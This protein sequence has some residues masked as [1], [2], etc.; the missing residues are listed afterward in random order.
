MA[1][2]TPLS[3]GEGEEVGEVKERS[4]RSPRLA[5]L[6]VFRGL[7]IALMIF[8]DY[9]GSI[10]P[11]VA[12]S[13]WHG[14][15]LADFVTPFFL[16]IA[17]IS[18]SLVYKRTSNKFLATKKA[19]L[20]TVKL[21]LLGILLQGGYFHGVNSLTFGVDLELIRWFGILQRIAIG[22][23][24]AALCEIWLS[25]IPWMNATNVQSYF[26]R[27]YPA[28]W[29]FVLSLCGIYLGLLYGLYVPD[30]QFEVQQAIHLNG[31][32]NSTYIVKKVTC[33]VIGDL[34]PACNSAGMIDRYFLGSEHLYK[35][36]AYRNLKICQTSEVSD[37]DNLPSWCQA[38]FDP[39]GLLGSLMAAVTCILGLQYGHILVRVEDHKDRLRYWLLFS[40]SFFSLGLFLVFIGHPLNKQLYTV[41]YTLLTTGSAG[42]TFCALY[43]LVDVRGC[44]CLTFVLEW[45]GKHSLSIFILVASNVAVI[46]VQGFFWRNPKNNIVHW[47]IS[48]FVHQ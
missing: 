15:R 45:M 43:L 25:K 47:V 5:S 18:L 9:A 41:S 46:C 11:F 44:R 27:G 42:L 26:S 38:P 20:R 39:E 28:H 33:G 32:W 35:K 22:Y 37:L 4:A 6:D 14:V 30:W 34:G 12:H 2:Y 19:V 16:F 3:G 21:F 7:S 8:V 23:I 1:D 17:G 29:I 10:F 31:P 24:I 40:V 13:P 48:L 36:P